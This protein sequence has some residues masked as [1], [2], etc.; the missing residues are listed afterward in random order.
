MRHAAPFYNTSIDFSGPFYIKEKK[1]QNRNTIKVYVCKFVCMTIKAVHLEIVSDLSTDGFLAAFRCF[2]ARRGIPT[3]VYSDNGTNFRG[4]NNYF[5]ELYVILNSDK[6][7][8][9]MERF[10]VEHRIAWH[11]IP[12]MAPHFGR[13]W[14]STVKS[15]KHHFKRV[16]GE[17]LFTF[18]ALNT[19]VIEIEGILNSRPISSISSN[20]NDLLVLMPAH[21]LIGRPL[22]A[23]SELDYSSV[24]ANRL[25]A[26]QHISKVRQDFWA[27][28]SLEYLNELQIRRKWTKEKKLRRKN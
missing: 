28:W 19:L 1:Y 4:A 22:T 21:C 10:A 13:L 6:H 16:V 23:L 26:W 17:L 9:Q 15:F 5:K 14:E 24:P 8:S 11:F 20:P 7:K 2:I 18:E 25:S 27:R 3:N 12:S